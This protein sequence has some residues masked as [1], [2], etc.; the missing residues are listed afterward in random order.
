MHKKTRCSHRSID[1]NCR[2]DARPVRDF[3]DSSRLDSAMVTSSIL[4]PADCTPQALA[5]FEDLVIEAGTVDPQGLTQRIRDA[6]RLLFL[7]ESNGQLVG[8][9]ALKHPLLSYRTRVFAK[10]EITALSDEYR[11]ELGW[12]AVA[13]SHQ[14]RGLSRRIIGELISLVDDE[15]LFATTRADA[16]A[17]RFATDYGFKP[18]GK[19]YPSGRGYDL[20]L[21]L[22]DVKADRRED[23]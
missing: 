3:G 5:D 14:G 18:A 16:R 17:M 4:S 6:C 11:I 12:V 7:R 21:Y 13:K 9:G 10:A 15:N 20:V 2:N 23:R 8:V 1:T 19:P 22:R